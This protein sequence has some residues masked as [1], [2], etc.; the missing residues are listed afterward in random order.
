MIEYIQALMWSPLM[1]T[2]YSEETSL[3][4]PQG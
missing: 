2:L 1:R 3:V 4:G